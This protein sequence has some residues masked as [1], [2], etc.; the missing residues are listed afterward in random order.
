MFL[1]SKSTQ[2]LQLKR[3]I[4]NPQVASVADT[5]DWL[6]GVGHGNYLY[7]KLDRTGTKQASS[8]HHYSGLSKKPDL[9]QRIEFCNHLAGLAQRH[10][11]DG[12]NA[13]SKSAWDLVSYCHQ[14]GQDGL[15][16]CKALEDLLHTLRLALD[17][18]TAPQAVMV[19]ELDPRSA[20]ELRATDLRHAIRKNHAPLGDAAKEAFAR[21][22]A[23]EFR[24]AVWYSQCS[25]RKLVA[26]YLDNPGRFGMAR[27]TP[28]AALAE[29]TACLGDTQ[30]LGMLPKRSVKRFID[31]L[32]RLQQQPWLYDKDSSDLRA[33]LERSALDWRQRFLLDQ[34]PDGA[35]PQALGAA[36]NMA[37]W[38]SRE[39]APGR[40]S[41]LGNFLDLLTPP[42]TGGIARE[43]VLGVVEKQIDNGLLGLLSEEHAQQLIDEFVIARAAVRS[44]LPIPF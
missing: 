25:A 29:L 12:D 31:D 13:V 21:K 7:C 10:V 37:D 34:H 9:S 33:G 18:R 3:N 17:A 35:D 39:Y 41:L 2:R 28:V 4:V 27:K 22:A 15:Q 19:A 1:G 24:L 8:K 26:Y 30:L 43:Y 16:K 44:K 40:G 5:D 38:V 23:Q 6:Q 36:Y 42:V 32:L 20:L 14:N 11:N